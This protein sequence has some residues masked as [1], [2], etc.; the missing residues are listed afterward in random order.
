M[1]C[2]ILTRRASDYTEISDTSRDSI[3]GRE[4]SGSALKIVCKKE[5]VVAVP[6]DSAHNSESALRWFRPASRRD[7]LQN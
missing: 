6:L 7:A 1:C 4:R 3:V 2:A 5:K